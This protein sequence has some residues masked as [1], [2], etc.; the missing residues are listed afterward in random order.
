VAVT[1]WSLSMDSITLCAIPGLRTS[2]RLLRTSG[3]HP[4][5]SAVTLL[6]AGCPDLNPIF[7]G[8]SLRPRVRSGYGRTRSD[9]PRGE[10]LARPRMTPDL[11]IRHPKA[12]LDDDDGD[13]RHDN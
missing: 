4:I 8:P 1:V 3:R 12:Y 5:V 10:H 6:R 13:S 2:L 11:G 9:L 7:S